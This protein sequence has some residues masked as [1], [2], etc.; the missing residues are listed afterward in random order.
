MSDQAAVDADIEVQEKVEL[1]P[2]LP[3]NWPAN[4]MRPHPIAAIFRMMDGPEFD[5]F[6]VSIDEKGLLEPIVVYEGQILDGRNRYL[7]AIKAG[8]FPADVDWRYDQHFIGFGGMGWPKDQMD[9]LDFVWTHN[10]QRRH[11]DKT[12]RALAAAR[13]HERRQGFRS[14]LADERPAN[15]REVAD[16]AGV[17]ERLVSSAHTVLDHGAP[18]L[19]EAVEQG[20]M[21][22]HTAEKLARE[23]DHIE[24]RL[25]AEQ[26]DKKAVRAAAKK[27]LAPP[28]PIFTRP[29]PL[30]KFA[31]FAQSAL[32]V[33]RGQK[34]VSAET[35]IAFAEK[36]EI[37]QREGEGFTY[38]DAALA[39]M[40]TLAA[41][42]PKP[43]PVPE[44]RRPTLTPQE[45]YDALI[46]LDLHKGRH[47]P[48]TAA[49]I[50]R[51][52]YA[53]T[54][55]IA[56]KQLVDDLGHKSGTIRSWSTRLKLTDP[57]RKAASQFKTR[58][59]AE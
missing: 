24:Q 47:T 34:D 28:P 53:A 2:A 39:A 1:A 35:L 27:K 13:Y 5:E 44:V 54:P 14:D 45:E 6:A 58:D 37:V 32:N 38:T 17:S 9:P 43:A 33:A 56:L 29:L 42:E 10:F 4:G 23:A 22:L 25:I 12:Q 51:A 21:P 31:R 46:A 57:A 19:V 18:E 41:A 48:A 59:A 11:D 52:A 36:Y 3:A 16:K 8:I 15:L 30:G 7:A 20:R 40:G 49:P 50:L 26:P 55:P